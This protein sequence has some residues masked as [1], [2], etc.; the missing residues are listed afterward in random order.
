MLQGLIA[1]ETEAGKDLF[2]FPVV[3]F[4]GL[5]QCGCSFCQD[6]IMLELQ[7][8]TDVTDTVTFGYNNAA[9]VGVFFAQNHAKQSRFPMAVSAHN[10]QS[11][12]CIEHKADSRKQGQLTIAFI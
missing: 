6:S 7:F 9:G 10:A 11:L 1:A 8:L 4:F 5:R 3:I 2:S 12:F